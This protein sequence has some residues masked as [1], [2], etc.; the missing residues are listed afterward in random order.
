MG[1]AVSE[2]DGKQRTGPS[3]LLLCSPVNSDVL[4]HLLK[5]VIRNTMWAL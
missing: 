3:F 4:I 5:F 1:A 2:G